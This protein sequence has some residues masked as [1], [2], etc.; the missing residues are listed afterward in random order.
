MTSEVD[1]RSMRHRFNVSK[2]LVIVAGAGPLALGACGDEANEGPDAP[3]GGSAAAGTRNVGGAGGSTAGR[4]GSSGGSAG[5]V[6]GGSAG[7]ASGGRAGSAGGAAGSSVTGG[8]AGSGTAGSGT[9]GSSVTGGTAG[10]GTAGSDAGASGTA[11]SAGGGGMAGG[12]SGGSGMAGGGSSGGGTGGGSACPNE[13]SPIGWA[14]V[15][16]D[17]VS[18]RGGADGETVTP[19]TAAELAEYAASAE[20]LVIRIQGTF[21]VPRLQ[22]TSNKTLLGVGA[23]ATINGGVRIRGSSDEL[24][25]NVIVRNLRVNGATSTVDSDA[26]QIYFAHH[27]W[28]DHCEIWDGPDGNLDITHA[29]NWVTVSWTKF[30]Y[31]MAYQRPSGEDSDHRFSSLI[32]HSDSNADEDSGRMK[33]T[34]HHNWWAER[35]IE[36]MP[37][38]RFGEVHVFNNYFSSADNNYCIGGGYE[39]RLLVQNNYFDG[40]KDPHRFQDDDDTAQIVANGNTYIGISDTTA[41]ATRGAAFTP[42]Y[43]AALAPADAALK[44]QVM[45]C[46]G[47]R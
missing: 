41:K 9:A 42:T 43:T 21:S 23:N 37:R 35:V 30:L 13:T 6:S 24:V 22:V 29:A 32:G 17:G 44:A 18:T 27:V 36:R 19:T 25:T 40:V 1:P 10:S 7:T 45:A 2:L 46:A 26:M 20:P 34:L 14:S 31:T 39:A 15:A 5:A 33:I 3:A 8:A 12:G 38:V 47:P 11:G 4:G 28:I 16:G